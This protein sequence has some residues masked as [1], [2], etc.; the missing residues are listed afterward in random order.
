MCCAVS[1]RA[2]EEGGRV[3]VLKRL[4]CSWTGALWGVCGEEDAKVCHG[5]FE[6]VPVE[7]D[8]AAGEDV[9]EV[10][11]GKREGSRNHYVDE[12]RELEVVGTEV[13]VRGANKFVESRCLEL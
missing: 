12:E 10:L 5:G 2:N 13:E 4:W 6:N 8:A 9:E 7:G 3:G 1:E 11:Q